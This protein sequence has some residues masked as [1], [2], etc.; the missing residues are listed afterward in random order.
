MEMKNDLN[1]LLQLSVP[2]DV[3]TVYRNEEVNID[4]YCEYTSGN[5]KEISI[6]I[7]EVGETQYNVILHDTFVIVWKKKSLSRL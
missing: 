3:I 6:N 5:L 4:D 7:N 1:G 2:E